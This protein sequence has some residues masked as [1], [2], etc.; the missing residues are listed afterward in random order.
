MAPLFWSS[1]CVVSGNEVANLK[2]VLKVLK[3]PTFA[4]VGAKLDNRLLT[5]QQ[6]DDA[7]E[8]P[9]LEIARATLVAT[10]SPASQ[11]QLLTGMLQQP[12][13]DLHSSLEASQS[14]LLSA[15]GRFA[16][17]EESEKQ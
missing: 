7:A 16:A 12:A 13:Q 3:A 14:D 6:L 17:S 1:T 5:P 10:I 2:K 4:V 8:L 11:L 15:L 9:S